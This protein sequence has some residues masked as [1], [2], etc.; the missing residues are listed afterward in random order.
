L[1]SSLI[2]LSA[3]LLLL[4][5]LSEAATKVPAPT[6]AVPQKSTQ[7]KPVPKPAPLPMVADFTFRGNHIGDPAELVIMR[8]MEKEMAKPKVDMTASQFDRDYAKREYET[9]IR[10]QQE[11]KAEC[12]QKITTTGEVSCS[13]PEQYPFGYGDSYLTYKF[14][15]QKFSGF[16]LSFP[17]IAYTTIETMVIGKYGEPHKTEVHQVQNYMGANFD[18]FI[19]TWN[20]KHGPMKLYFRYPDL[21]HG[22]LILEDTAVKKQAEALK[23]K[24]LHEAGKAAF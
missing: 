3:S 1:K 19:A 16:T 7:A 8:T 9:S 6:K 24:E 10:R 22:F 14:F 23:Q 18:Q 21:E 20:T 11:A 2:V 17:L 15:D 4:F 12:M 5:P 13:D